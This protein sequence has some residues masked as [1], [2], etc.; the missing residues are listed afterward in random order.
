MKKDANVYLAHILD[1]IEWIEKD[2]HDMSKEDFV[3]NIPMQDAV[4]RRIQIIGEAAKLLPDELKDKAPDV[5]WKKIAGM[6]DK[7]IHDYVDVDVELVWEVVQKDVPPLKEAV[8]KLLKD[9]A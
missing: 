1:S 7:V 8:Q 5:P 4:M 3:G 9:A 6:R 2:T